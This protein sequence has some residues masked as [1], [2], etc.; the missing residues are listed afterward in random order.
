VSQILEFAVIGLGTGGLY[1]LFAL[2]VVLTYRGSGVINFAQGAIGMVG[3]YAFWDLMTN[4]G[5]PYTMAALIGVLVSGLLGLIIFLL[6]MRP[7]RSSPP[8]TGLIATLAILV[9][10]EQS[11]GLHFTQPVIDVRALLPTGTWTIG[12]V[13]IGQYTLAVLGTSMVLVGLLWWIYRFT[14]F[15]RATSANVEN[16]R[17]LAALGISPERVAAVNWAVGGALAGLAGVLLAPVTGLAVDQYTLLILP[18]LAAAVVGDLVSFPATLVAGL[19]IGVIQAEMNRYVSAQGWSQAAPFLIIIAVLVFRIRGERLRSQIASL[20]PKVGTGQVRLSVIVPLVALTAIVIQ[21]GLNAEWQDAVTTTIL[22]AIIILS[23]VVVTGYSGQL[24]LAQYALAGLGAYV[25]GRLVAT[26]EMPFVAALLVALGAA[27]PIGLI[28]GA[29]CVRTKGIN[30]AIATLGLAVTLEDLLFTNSHYTGG[31]DGTPVGTPHLFGFD[32]GDVAHPNRYALVCLGALLIV[33]LGVANL[34]RG[35][36]GR[37]LVAIRSNERAA[38]SLG[39]NVAGAK[40]F[41]FTFGSVIAALGGVLLAFRTPSIIYPNFTTL[42]SIQIVLYAVVGGVGWIAG[43]VIGGTFTAG[44]VGAQLLDTV[45]HG[46]DKYLPLIGGVLLILT[47]LQAKDGLAFLNAHAASKTWRRL[48]G[49]P[50]EVRSMDLAPSFQVHRVAAAHLKISDLT[51]DFGGVRALD[52]VSLELKPGEVVGL[53]GPNGA[54]KTTLID[55]ITGFVRPR[56]GDVM[57]N[58]QSVLRW[59]P[60]RRARAGVARS[61]QSLEL[62]EDMT[63]LDN[64]RTACEPHDVKAFILD[65]IYPRRVPLTDTTLA[66]IAECSLERDALRFPTELSYAQR[67][68]VAIARAVAS[69]PSVLLLDEPAAGLDEVE[70][71]ELARLIRRLAR[72]WGISVLVIEHDIEMV[73]DVCDRVDVLEFG[74]LVA[75]GTPAEIRTSPVVIAAYIGEEMD[76]D[77]DT[78]HMGAD[79]EIERTRSASE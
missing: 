25:A 30:L 50:H 75:S 62:F 79:L 13:I 36:S 67:R 58:E 41:A 52:G 54:G 12:G 48:R 24:S 51:V 49:G 68:L 77:A 61:F 6:V 44:S 32:I 70:T 34:R 40:L 78:A 45:G 22:T 76:G 71:D 38:A 11:V 66:A 29:I 65:L 14:Q 74:M 60:T 18:A 17:A 19:A 57:L 35:R 73:F 37:R 42:G 47:V 23:V 27:V 55:V 5:V 4:F 8:V 3:T 21:F 72:D 16:R 28:V 1:V 9:V 20:L 33:S 64:L 59:S 10:L 26:T 53:I 39:V 63:V 43:A 46:A 69:N 15:G 56:Q 7:L 31:Q 2:G